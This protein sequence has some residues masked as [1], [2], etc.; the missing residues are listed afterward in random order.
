M[1][2]LNNLSILKIQDNLVNF[3]EK[4]IE[5]NNEVNAWGIVLRNFFEKGN[6]ITKIKI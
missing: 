4:N 6:V 2:N 5:D 1:K 3:H